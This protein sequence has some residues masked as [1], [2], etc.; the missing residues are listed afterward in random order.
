M[1]SSV[2][3]FSLYQALQLL[4]YKSYHM[5]EAVG[6]GALHMA[7]FEEALRCKYLGAGQPYGKAEFDKWFADYDGEL[8]YKDQ[9]P[10][11]DYC[12]H[13]RQMSMG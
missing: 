5:A 3:T 7:I 6:R 2:G 12:L 1:K 13:I 9:A 8:G 11:D 10:M 4:G